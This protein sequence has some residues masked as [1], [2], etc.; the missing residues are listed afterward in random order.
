MKR[1]P[2]ASGVARALRGVRAAA[3]RS[4]KGLNHAASQR[5]AKGD[6][7]GAEALVAQ[8]RQVQQFQ[9][10][11][12]VLHARWRELNS[13]GG[14]RGEKRSA[15]PLW[16]YY[17]PILQALVQAGGECERA[18]VEARVERLMSPSFQPGDRDTM[19]QGRERWRVMV[20]RARK[21]LAAEG[22]IEGA[23]GKV[24]RITATGRRAAEKPVT[25]SATVG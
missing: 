19:A 21:P 4:L 12:G 3:Q 14:A 11:V 10:E 1:I 9:A 7:A 2:H 25:T 16:S 15:T 5:M 23:K 20:K 8:G 6:Y 17:T 13:G 18:D 22:W 24:W